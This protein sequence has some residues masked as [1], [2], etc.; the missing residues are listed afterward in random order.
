MNVVSRIG[1]SYWKS[2][3]TVGIWETLNI[4][5]GTRNNITYQNNTKDVRNIEKDDDQSCDKLHMFE[6]SQPTCMT[7][8]PL[9]GRS[10]TELHTMYRRLVGAR[11]YN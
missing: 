10:T 8:H 5:R 7:F 9:V 6:F 1:H 4:Y 11:P 2:K 3:E